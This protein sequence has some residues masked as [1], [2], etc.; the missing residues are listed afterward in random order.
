[1][2]HPTDTAALPAQLMAKPALTWDEFWSGI[3][4]LPDTT[5]EQLARE[6]DGPKFFLLGRRRY[7]RTADV[8]EYIDHRAKAMPYFPRRNRRQSEGSAA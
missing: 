5:A 3:L 2:E 8:I 1:M 4:G 6:P 7:I